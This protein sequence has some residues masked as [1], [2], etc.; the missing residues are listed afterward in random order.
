MEL[1]VYE[2]SALVTPRFWWNSSG[3]NANLCQTSAA[4]QAQLDYGI[5]QTVA[6][7]AFTST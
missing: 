3:S 4:N 5:S 2:A 6:V 1:L 7:F